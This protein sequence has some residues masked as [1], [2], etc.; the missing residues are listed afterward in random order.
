MSTSP[1]SGTTASLTSGATASPT[2][3]TDSVLSS[4]AFLKLLTTQLQNQDPLNPVSSSDFTS[5]LAQLSSL[6]GMQQLNTSF[7]SLLT[8]QQM[9]QGASLIG[10]NVVY[11]ADSNGTLAQGTVTAVDLQN[12]QMQLMVG[13]NTVPLA[14]VQGFTQ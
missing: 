3:G 10:R 4:D 5:Q 6:Q 1:I 12:N 8:L 13:G 14:Q 2:S 11:S 7:T 9:T